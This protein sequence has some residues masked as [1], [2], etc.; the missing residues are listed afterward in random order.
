MTVQI[1]KNAKYIGG[2][3]ENMIDGM[4]EDYNSWSSSEQM[5]DEFANGFEIRKG[6]KYIKV[7]NRNSVVAFIVNSTTDKLFQLG[8][9]LKPAGWNAPARNA[10]RGNVLEGNYLMN[11]T[12]PMY[13]S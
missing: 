3:I 8:D 13:L 9:I 6:Q 12:G 10:P 5:K 7:I 2:G 1:T 4:I 11:W